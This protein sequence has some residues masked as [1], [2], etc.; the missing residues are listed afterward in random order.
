MVKATADSTPEELARRCLNQQGGDYD[1]ARRM[2]QIAFGDP[3]EIFDVLDRWQKE[4]GRR[5]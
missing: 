2:A 1:K 4:R 3:K 5:G